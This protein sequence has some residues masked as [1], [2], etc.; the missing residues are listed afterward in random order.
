M[1]LDL[2]PLEEAAARQ[3]LPGLR[4]RIVPPDRRRGT[5]FAWGGGEL[6][7][8]EH[9]V[10]RCPPGDAAALLVDSILLERR[11]AGVRRAACAW[12]AGALAAAAALALAGPGG[13]G[14]PL[15]WTVVCL[16]LASAALLAF[17][18]RARAAVQADDETV[19]LLGDATP[20]VRGL[21]AMDQ[22]ELRVAGRRLRA[23]PDLHRRAERL[24]RLHALCAAPGADES[25]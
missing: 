9:V 22:D 5:W 6:R 19:A 11:M 2:T 4:A 7:V 15:V 21:N 12:G 16:G 10:D 18:L 17:T 8:S 14:Q 20:L 1:P 23:R 3:G 25:P 13:L 24:V